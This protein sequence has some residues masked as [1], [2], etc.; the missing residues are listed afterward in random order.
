MRL[1]LSSIV[2]GSWFVISLVSGLLPL[3]A[4][5]IMLENILL[6]PDFESWLGYD[7]LGRPIADRLI[8]GARI[9]LSV[10]IFVVS[11]SFVLGT[12]IGM[13]AA[14]LGGWCDKL[15]VFIIDVFIAFPGILLAI[16]LS[17]LMRPG[18][19]NAVVALSIVG[20]VA[21]ARLARAQTLTIKHREHV[22]AAKA[23]GVNTIRIVVTHIFPLILAP[24]VVE[25]TFAIA[26]T[27]VAEAG[28]SFLGLGV[29]PPDP[30][31]GSMIRDGTQFMLVA[32]HM[33][34]VPSVAILAVVLSINI[35]GDA[36]RDKID[37]R[38]N[39]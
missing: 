20:W 34:L 7:D 32:P 10:A 9:S 1:L 12:S 3:S 39:S 22:V 30:S 28:L 26:A 2:I 25:A 18:I 35:L 23:L 36:L 27:V 37:S 6:L 8:L 29:Q 13:M 14:W 24:L 33:V 5:N 15:I 19:S 11:I 21:F 38:T 4:D 17:G 31:W 16:V